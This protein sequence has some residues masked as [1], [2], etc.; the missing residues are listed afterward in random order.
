MPS[1]RSFL[2]VLAAA[3]G[4][5]GPARGDTGD[6]GWDGPWIEGPDE[7]EERETVTLHVR[8]PPGGTCDWAFDEAID[9]GGSTS[10][11]TSVEVTCPECEG[12]GGTEVYSIYVVCTDAFDNAR[13]DFGDLAVTC[14]EDEVSQVGGC[15]CGS[16]RRP[17]GWAGTLGAALVAWLASRRRASAEGLG[18]GPRGG[19]ARH[20]PEPRF[21]GG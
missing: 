3:L 15:E 20:G 16:T 1:N 4:P 13:W 7:C 12:P 17:A 9:P 6:T 8:P 5:A 21:P 11:A 18:E 19:G 10:G 14:A 2:L